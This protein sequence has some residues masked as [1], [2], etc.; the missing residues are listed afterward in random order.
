MDIA[1][2][3]S[4]DRFC[5][6]RPG[7]SIVGNSERDAPALKVPNPLCCDQKGEERP[8]T[9]GYDL[10]PAN[11]V[12]TLWMTPVGNSKVSQISQV[13][14]QVRVNQTNGVIERCN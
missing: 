8:T 5:A 6:K 14:G 4:R 2:N 3:E 11:N 10:S 13:P 9:P 7:V 12:P 1:G